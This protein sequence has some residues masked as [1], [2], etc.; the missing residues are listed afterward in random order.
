MAAL[1]LATLALSFVTRSDDR[2]ALFAAG[3]V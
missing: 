2:T 1:M 3:A